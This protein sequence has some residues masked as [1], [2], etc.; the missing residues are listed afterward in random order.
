MSKGPPSRR[1]ARRA[2]ARADDK[3]ARARERL[4]ALEAGASPDRPIEVPTASVVE[5]TARSMPCPRCG[6]ARRVDE[7]AAVVVGDRRLRVARVH[8]PACGAS[9]QIWFRLGTVLPS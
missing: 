1:A 8:C 5:P 7:H 6:A 9:G 2:A 3:L 4:A